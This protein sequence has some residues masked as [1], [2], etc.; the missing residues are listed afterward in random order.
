MTQA[1]GA[2]KREIGLGGAVMLGLGAMVGT[3]VF[4]S[5]GIGAGVTGPSILLAVALAAVVA[6]CNALSSAQ[7]AAA[8]PVSGGTYEYGYARLSP[9]LGFSAGWMFLCAKSA[10]AAAAALGAAGYLIELTRWPIPPNIAGAVA[11]LAVTGIVLAGVRRSSRANV[12]IVTV[13][14][15]ALTAFVAVG[16]WRAGTQAPAEWRPF[17]AGASPVGGFLEAVALMFVAFTGYAR[18]ATL[19]EEVIEP[20]RTIPRAIIATLVIT[21][22]LYLAVAGVGIATVG[23]EALARAAAGDM[24]PLVTA[25]T[26][27]GAPW[28]PLLLTVGALTAMLGVLLNLLLG[29]SRVLLAMG[30]RSDVPGELAGISTSGTPVAAIVV[31]GVAVSALALAGDINATWSFS[32]FSVLVYYAITNLAALRLAPEE[33]LYPRALAVAGLAACVFLAFW[34]EWRIWLLGLT[35]IAVGA[36][37]H[38]TARR[39]TGRR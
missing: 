24:A 12:A 18:L 29:L 9:L 17:F 4:V 23:A 2:L 26:T 20:R 34:V 10:S 21:T 5:I 38:E 7:L 33:R 31:A 19:G 22:I 16:L 8:M 37:W 11:A 39:L 15:V 27:F 13:T 3:G 32:A 35:L 25:A 6:V 36:L 28:L 14:L 30:R 1:A